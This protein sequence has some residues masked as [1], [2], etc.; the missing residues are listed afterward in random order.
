MMLIFSSLGGILKTYT[1]C[2]VSH[3]RTSRGKA[4]TVRCLINGPA[5]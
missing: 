3:S 5:Y 1:G 2:I 4:S